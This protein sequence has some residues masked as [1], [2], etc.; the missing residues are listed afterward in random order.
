MPDNDP[1]AA[2]HAWLD[3]VE[4]AAE[5]GRT[6]LYK[7]ACE[8]MEAAQAKAPNALHVVAAALP[9]ADD[10]IREDASAVKAWVAEA[11][12]KLPEQ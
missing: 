3:V 1:N 9:D 12:S 5:E 2:A 11:R 7:I 6:D 10:A 4:K 8:A